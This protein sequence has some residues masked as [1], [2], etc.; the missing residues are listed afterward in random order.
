MTDWDRITTDIQQ[1]MQAVNQANKASEA[2]REQPDREHL[3]NFQEQIRTLYLELQNIQ[4]MMSHE[5]EFF[6]D[7][8]ADAMSKLFTGKPAP[9]HKA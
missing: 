1:A 4:Y 5:D 2:L 8:V 7:E 3:E 6:N 9:W